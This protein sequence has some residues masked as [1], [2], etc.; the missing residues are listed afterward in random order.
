MKKFPKWGQYKKGQK[1][2][3]KL[4]RSKIDLFV[5]CPR[6]FYLDRVCGVS[7]PSIPSFTLNNAVDVLLKKEFDIYRTNKETHPLMKKY[8]IDAVPFD[9]PKMNEWRE[10]FVGVQYFHEPTN[11]LIFGAVDDL[12]QNYKN[13]IH[14]VDYKST[15]KD[16]EVKLDDKW[17]DAYKRQMEVYQWLVRK[18]DLNVS[19]V[20]Y[21]VYANGLKDKETFNAKLEFD[22][23]VLPYEGD[24][25]WIED[26]IFKIKETL[27]KD[28]LPEP[29]PDC[30]HC[31][32]FSKREEVE[33]SDSNLNLTIEM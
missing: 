16:E 13:E 31:G 5:E 23:T 24:T 30:E 1:E 27:D 3:F 26:T 22:M 32:L 19:D 15:S 10:N 8:N 2:P 25:F 7:R 28:V 14:I 12:W 33:K 29:S 18:N 21:F 20:G 17:K 6:C 9:H 4:S 11:L